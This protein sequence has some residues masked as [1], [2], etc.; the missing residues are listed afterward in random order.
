VTAAA[1][2]ERLQ[3]RGV[4]L[5]VDG[6]RLR[7]RPAGAISADEVEAIKRHKPAI[8]RLLATTTTAPDDPDL[9]PATVRDTLGA[10]P[11]PHML[12]GIAWDVRD[13]LRELR[14]GIASGHLPPRR[15]VAGRPLADW[16]TLDVLA[17][18]LGAAR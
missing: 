6:D 1:L 11:D 13:A 8:L 9:D 10:S 4:E 2:V 5:R 7:L 12:A 15:L 3:A 16:L 14:A 18:L 17:A